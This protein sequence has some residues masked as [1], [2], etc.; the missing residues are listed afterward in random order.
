MLRAW[1][2]GKVIPFRPPRDP[3]G[4]IRR[5]EEELRRNWYK[6]ADAEARR[7]LRHCAVK[8]PAQEV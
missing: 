5:V 1:S 7:V 8:K 3:Y 6:V 4:V 2:M